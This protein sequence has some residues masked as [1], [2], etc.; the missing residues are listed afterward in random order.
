MTFS[1]SESFGDGYETYA[2][3]IIIKVHLPVVITLSFLFIGLCSW[4]LR[5]RKKRVSD[6]FL[7]L[8]FVNSVII[9]VAF[10]FFHIY[11]YVREITVAV[12]AAYNYK[13]D[14]TEVLK[15]FD[16]EIQEEID[17]SICRPFAQS[18]CTVGEQLTE[19]FTS[20][21]SSVQS[22][23]SD[24]LVNDASKLYTEITD[25]ANLGQNLTHGLVIASIFIMWFSLF[26]PN[27]VKDNY[28]RR[29][30]G[31]TFFIGA[32]LLV[33][34]FLFFLSAVTTSD[35]CN[36]FVSV[37]NILEDDETL[38]FY[39]TCDPSVKSSYPPRLLEESFVTVLKDEKD[40]NLVH[41]FCEGD[42]LAVSLA[43]KFHFNIKKDTSN[44]TECCTGCNATLMDDI[45][46]RLGS[47]KNTTGIWKDITCDPSHTYLKNVENKI[48]AL[49]VPF[50]ANFASLLVLSVH[51]IFTFFLYSG[52]EG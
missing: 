37:V 27:A 18:S 43:N 50:F 35:I 24:D 5:Q 45:F 1:S 21:V 7:F 34:S 41:L 52:V 2:R 19:P 6:G 49:F 17:V 8:G 16:K 4:I 25:M 28:R 47:Y 13:V 15:N 31:I 38:N 42:S 11:S 12:V 44:V 36:D 14:I 29:L 22:V 10:F 48:C 23:P 3:K 51:L 30:Q 9:F 39:L 26:L 20:I 32:I 46:L 40:E 33:I